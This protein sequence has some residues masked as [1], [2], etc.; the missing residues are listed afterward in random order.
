MEEPKPSA[1]LPILVVDDDVT[2]LSFMMA[3][4]ARHGRPYEVAIT[5]DQALAI[6]R[7]TKVRAVLL[8][9]KLPD[10]DGV[11]VLREIVKDPDHP[12]VI[13]VSGAASLESAREAGSLGAVGYLDKP[14]RIAEVLAVVDRVPDSGQ[15][16]ADLLSSSTN[17][18]PTGSLAPT[19]AT[20]RL[21]E[22][23]LRGSLQTVDF[24]NGRA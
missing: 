23:V 5:G 20:G 21:A 1:E 3:A 11:D 9:R 13:L 15:R 4:L 16:H 19:A 6:L 12:P 17:Y 8:D 2:F 18:E 24:K 7:R 10:G 22:V 14:V